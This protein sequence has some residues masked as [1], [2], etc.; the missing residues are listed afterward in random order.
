MAGDEAAAFSQPAWRYAGSPGGKGGSG[1]GAVAAQKAGYLFGWAGGDLSYRMGWGEE[2]RA[3]WPVVEAGRRAADA[4]AMGEKMGA[5]EAE[6]GAADPFPPGS[7][8]AGGV[9]GRKGVKAVAASGH[10]LAVTVDGA[11]YSFGRNWDSRRRKAG[12]LGRK[13]P[14]GRPGRVA[15]VAGRVRA[16]AAGKFHSV[17]VTEEGVVYTWGCNGRGQLGRQTRS[18]GDRH[19][20][21]PVRGP[22]ENVVVVAAAA[23]PHY[24]LALLP[25]LPVGDRH[26]AAP[27]R[28]ALENVVVVAA[29]AGPH[30]SLAL[31]AGGQVFT[32]GLNLFSLPAPW[33]HHHDLCHTP[34][35]A[36][37]SAAAA[38]A[39]AVVA[40]GSA[41]SSTST[42]GG[43]EKELAAALA[44]A[45]EPR[46]VGGALEGESVVEIAAGEEHWLALTDKGHV[47]ACSTGFNASGIRVN[48]AIHAPL[49]AHSS[50]S[51]FALPHR[52]TSGPLSSERASTIGA[53]AGASFAV[54]A[55]SQ[56]LLS[57]GYGG[58]KRG[59]AAAAAAAG[60]GAAAAAGSV[61]LGR[62]G[63]AAEEP[64]EVMGEEEEGDG[65]LRLGGVVQVVGGASFVLART[66]TGQVFSWGHNN[67]H[68]LGRPTS[69]S[70]DPLPGLV[71]G[72]ACL[73]V[74]TVAAGSHHGLV[75]G[76]AERGKE[77]EVVEMEQVVKEEWER[78][79]SGEDK[80]GGGGGAG[81]AGGEG[82]AGA[83]WGERGGGG[84]GA[85]EGGKGAVF[86]V[87]YNEHHRGEIMQ[88]AGEWFAQL[89]Q[90]GFDPAFRNPC[91]KDGSGFHCLPYFLVIGA[92][93]SGARDFFHR[94]TMVHPTAVLLASPSLT[95]LSPLFPHPLFPCNQE[96]GARDFFHRLTMVHPTAVLPASMTNLEWWDMR[97]YDPLDWWDMREYDP[98]DWWDMREYDPFDWYTEKFS[99]AAAHIATHPAAIA[100]EVTPSLLTHSGILARGPHARSFLLPEL[101]FSLLPHARFIVLL[102]NPIHRFLLPELVFS[103]L[104]HACFIVLLRNPIHRWFSSFLSAKQHDDSHIAFNSNDNSS[105]A[106]DAFARHVDVVLPAIKGCMVD[107][108]PVYCSRLL[109]HS[110]PHVCRS[111]YAYFLS[112][113]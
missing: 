92:M 60:G 7:H 105:S 33:T 83:G 17:A 53:A 13:G 2:D 31:S 84:G 89:P 103:L 32:W 6:K 20:A 93:R 24:S 108:S 25:S 45:A 26:E 52:I 79:H 41:G 113:S 109:F 78:V 12:Q 21:A 82:A 104:P 22:L 46:R 5:V 111:M 62:T 85:G 69:N 88:V 18:M 71:G 4:A 34:T 101:V 87:I 38:A 107:H 44:L 64:S 67:Y 43:L 80:T 106:A 95:H 16:V 73:H 1:T 81:R 28:G 110:F 100:G 97:E 54:M 50:H 70:A 102:R 51:R 112:V 76:R 47:Y 55:S 19:K 65:G 48:P 94:L 59:L 90:S 61:L 30:Y 56:Q 11:L 75:F 9:L 66:S 37:S 49:L 14:F 36:S 40:A 29:A 39:A 74:D 68:Q 15:G 86:P 42:S 91:W 77:L 8:R 10:T 99:Q 63:G 72:L 35:A 57:W 96:S 98:L 27:V 58:G 3:A 23:G